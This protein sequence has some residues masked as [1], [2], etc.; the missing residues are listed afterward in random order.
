MDRKQVQTGRIGSRFGNADTDIWTPINVE[1]IR[2]MASNACKNIEDNI[3]GFFRREDALTKRGKW[4]AF[5][6]TEQIAGAVLMMILLICGPR[7]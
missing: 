3:L 5:H 6:P 1:R 2:V 4:E 7:H